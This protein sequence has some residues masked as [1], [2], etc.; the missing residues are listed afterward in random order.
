[1]Y[2]L[3]FIPLLIG[4]TLARR[5]K[6]HNSN[7][8]PKAVQQF[9]NCNNCYAVV[10]YDIL[11]WHKPKLNVTVESLMDDSRQTCAGGS[12]KKIWDLYMTKTIVT[13]AKLP[14]LIRLLRKGPVAL[15][16]EKG[17]LVTA[18]SA[19]RHGVLIRDPRDGK[20][21]IIESKI[22]FNYVTYPL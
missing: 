11:K 9:K 1:M 16:V 13:T 20:E 21:K 18:V 4:L 5:R 17:H 10:A 8:L 7:T 3:W 22:F 14:K 19:S 2:R 12:A 15:A 6:L